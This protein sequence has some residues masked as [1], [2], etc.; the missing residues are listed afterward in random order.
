VGRICGT[1]GRD[2]KLESALTNVAIELLAL[3]LH[4]LE[5]PSLNFSLKPGYTVNPRYNG[6]I[7]G[8]DVR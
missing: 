1:Q 6:L 5:V 4:I 7:E 3:L 2:E 8:R